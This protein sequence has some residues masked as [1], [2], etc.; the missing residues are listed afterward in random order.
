MELILIIAL[1]GGLLGLF[2]I[3]RHGN[4]RRNPFNGRHYSSHEDYLNKIKESTKKR[5]EEE[6]AQQEYKNNIRKDYL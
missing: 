4:T 2:F 3:Q 5:F 6:Q 1:I